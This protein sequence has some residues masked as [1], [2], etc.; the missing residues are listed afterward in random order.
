VRRLA[1]ASGKSL[2]DFAGTPSDLRFPFDPAR[3]DRTLKPCKRSD[4]PAVTTIDPGARVAKFTARLVIH[5]DPAI[6]AEIERLADEARTS[7]ASV[8]RSA[9]RAY[10]RRV[11][12]PAARRAGR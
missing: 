2:G 11:D 3:L 7:T 8:V 4:A 10:L 12:P 9:V 1:R 6:V 5:E